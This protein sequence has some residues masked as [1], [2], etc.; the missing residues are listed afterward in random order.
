[1]RVCLPLDLAAPL[2]DPRAISDRLD[3]VEFFASNERLREELRKILKGSP[4][5][6]RALSR[7]ALGRGGPRDLAAVR[8]G[9]RLAAEAKLAL[10]DPGLAEPPAGIAAAVAESRR[11]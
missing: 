11:P 10:A 2:T 4:D 7:L 6:E 1:M 3:M 8:D 5:L 9:L